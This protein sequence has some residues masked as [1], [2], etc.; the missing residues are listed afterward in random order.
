M[1]AGLG[2]GCAVATPRPASERPGN[3]AQPVAAARLTNLFLVAPGLY[4]SAQPTA[5]GFAEAE[6]LGIRTVIN[7]REGDTDTSGLSRTDLFERRI[8]MQPWDVDDKHVV[9]FLRL[10]G[11]RGYGPF[12]VHCQ[13]GSDRTG[14]MCAMYR[15]V[16]EGWSKANAID[17]ME[18][19]GFGF[20]SIWTN[21]PDYVRNVDIEKIRQAVE[22]GKER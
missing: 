17:E 12:L 22:G 15:V 13:H 1:V 9:A 7:L 10:V 3:W 6:R 16:V 21:I 5:E 4:R 14:V 18:H 11:Q 8:P 2:V 20:H 19:G